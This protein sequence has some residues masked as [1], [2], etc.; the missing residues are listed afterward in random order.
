LTEGDIK[1]VESM[2]LKVLFLGCQAALQ[3]GLGKYCGIQ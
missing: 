3:T 1:T 2:K